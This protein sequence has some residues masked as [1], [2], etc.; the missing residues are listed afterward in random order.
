VLLEGVMDPNLPNLHDTT[1][2]RRPG[3]DIAG[4]GGPYD[5]NAV[6][7]STRDAVLLSHATVSTVET[8]RGDKRETSVALLLEGRINKTA[9]ES[10][11]LYLLNVDGVAA[12][13]TELLG[14]GER[15]ERLGD[16]DFATE[17]R[18]RLGERWDE[19]P[20]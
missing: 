14:V 7:V 4:P 15:E 6:V 12:I 5:R 17:L 3:G 19:M 16:S 18:R 9:D 8:R 2:P 20:K 11:V 10:R 13:I 1:D